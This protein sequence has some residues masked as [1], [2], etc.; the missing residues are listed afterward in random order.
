ML[1]L[2]LCALKAKL[3]SEV[4]PGGYTFF[5]LLRR[6]WS[7]RSDRKRAHRDLA[8]F[9]RSMFRWVWDF[10]YA[11]F[12]LLS[13]SHSRHLHHLFCLHMKFT[14]GDIIFHQKKS[15]RCNLETCPCVVL[16]VALSPCG[17]IAI[18]WFRGAFVITLL[19]CFVIFKGHASLSLLSY[20]GGVPQSRTGRWEQR[21]FN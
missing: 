18:S 11:P 10:V 16:T 2:K 7:P 19:R 9:S 6:N 8:C 14:G 5:N 3:V 13:N 20:S 1:E 12:K 4:E 17:S 21:G 15:N